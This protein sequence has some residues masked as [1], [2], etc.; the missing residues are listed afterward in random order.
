VAKIGLV[1]RVDHLRRQQ[2]RHRGALLLVALDVGVE[3]VGEVLSE[4]L[5]ELDEVLHRV[6]ALP[7]RRL[8]L[9]L[10]DVAVAGK[11]GPVRLDVLALQRVVE[12]LVGRVCPAGVMV[13]ALFG[14]TDLLLVTHAVHLREMYRVRGSPTGGP[15][16][17]ILS[18]HDRST[19]SVRW[20]AG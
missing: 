8:P 2:H 17:R 9:L 14:R 6:R 5:L 11:A 18:P 3:L 7:L 1:H 10:R 12:G 13:R 19:S 16:G 4:R 20:M 15:G